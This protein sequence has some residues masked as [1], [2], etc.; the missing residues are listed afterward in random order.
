MKRFFWLIFVTFLSFSSIKAQDFDFEQAWNRIKKYEN[1]GLPKSGLALTDSIYQ[2]GKK[3]GDIE[4]QVK[5]IVYR[6]KYMT[7][8]KEEGLVET[9][10]GMEKEIETAEF[11]AKPLMQS[12]LADFYWGYY[13]RNYWKFHNR[14]ELAEIKPKDIRTWDLKT[15]VV[16][17]SKYHE[18]ALSEEELL[19]ETGVESIS[20]LIYKG[21]SKETSALRP[22]LYDLLANRALAFYSNSTTG[23]IKPK[24]EFVM[25]D[26]RYFDNAELFTKMKITS[27]DSLN[28]DYKALLIYQKLIDFH[29]NDMDKSAL[30]DVDLARIWFVFGKTTVQNKKNLILNALFQLKNKAPKNPITSEVIYT[31]AKV[32]Y[33]YFTGENSSV[34]TNRVEALKLCEQVI[35]KYPESYGASQ[36]ASLKSKIIIKTFSLKL[37]KLNSPK[38]PMLAKLTYRNSFK[39]YLRIYKV[40]T[41]YKPQK[42]TDVLK[43]KMVLDTVISVPEIKD[44]YGHS[45]KFG[46]RNLPVGHYY[47]VVSHVQDFNQSENQL[48][49]TK[50]WSTNMSMVEEKN[51]KQ[52]GNNF[53]V[54]DNLTGQATPNITFKI[55][56]HKYN[57]KTRKYEYKLQKTLKTDKNGKVEVSKQSYYSY[58]IELENGDDKVYFDDYFYSS[59]G[60][61]YNYSGKK[62]H[63]FTDRAIYR[64]GQTMYF[65]G[66]LIQYDKDGNGKEVV[67]NQKTNIY[68]YDANHQK[69]KTLELSTNEYG[70]VSG[71]FDLPTGRLGGQWHIKWGSNTKYFSVE[72]YKRPKFFVKA[73][74]VEKS[75]KINGKV[76]LSG[77]AKAYAGF[78]I[79][80]AKVEYSVTR[81]PRIPYWYYWWMP[82]PSYSNKVILNGNTTTDENGEYTIDFVAEPD[83]SINPEW[84]P[85]FTYQINVSVTD[86]NGETQTTSYSVKVGYISLLAHISVSNLIEIKKQN[87][88]YV[89]TRNLN[90]EKIPSSGK[91]TIEQ[92]ETPKTFFKKD[93][94]S[95]TDTFLLTEQ[96]FKKLFPSDIYNNENRTETWKT[97]KTVYSEKISIDGDSTFSNDFIKKF[98]AGM[99]KITYNTQ[100]KFGEEVKAIKYFTIYNQTSKK[101]IEHKMLTTQL[102]QYSYQPGEAAQIFVSSADKNILVN[103]S[104]EQN[105]KE[106]KSGTLTLNNETQSI[107]FPLEEKH[108]GNIVFHAYTTKNSRFY[109]STNTIYVPWTNK[110]LTVEFE[111]FRNK[112]QPGQKEEWKMKV[113]GPKGEKFAAEFVAT[114]Y[115]AS[116]ESFKK[117]SWYLSPFSNFYSQ[118]SYTDHYSF[119]SVNSSSYNYS[120]N[121]PKYAK[122][123][124]YDNLKLFGLN[125]NSNYY[126]YSYDELD[127]DNGTFGDGF[128]ESE[129]SGMAMDQITSTGGKLNKLQKKENKIP[130]PKKKGDLEKPLTEQQKQGKGEGGESPKVKIRTKLQENAFFMPHISTDTDGKFVLK[131]TI[132]EALT[133]WKMIGL[134]HTPDLKTGH[135]TNTLKTQKELMVIP[136]APRFFRENDKMKFSAKVSNIS[137][138]KLSGKV[139]LHLLNA[140][141]MIIADK[142]FDLKEVDKNFSLEAGKSQAFFW[143][144]TI[145]DDIEIA[146][147]RIVAVGGKFSDG[148]EA[149]IPVLPNRMLVT[150]TFPLPIRGKQ[151]KTF[152]FKNM[153]K[154]GKSNTLKNHKLTLEFT[155]NPVWYAVQ[156]LPYLMEYPYECAEQTFNRFYANSI[157]AHIVSEKPKIKEIFEQWEKVDTS[158]LLSNL[159][160]NQE[161]KSV[162]L[163]ETPWVM[164]A[165][166][167]TE[168]KK[169]IALLFNYSKMAKNL[170]SAINKLKQM[171]TPN[172]GWAWF[173]GMRD[174]RYITQYIVTGMARLQKI[175]IKASKSNKVMK[176]IDKAVPYLDDRM[177]EDYEWIMKHSLD[178]QADHLGYYAIQYLYARSYFGFAE[179]N[180]PKSHQKAYDYWMRQAKKYWLSK[181]KMSQGMLSVALSRFDEKTVASDIIASLKEHALMDEEMGMY[182]KENTGGYYWY[183]APIETQSVLIE[184]FDEVKQD[185]KSVEEMQIWLLKQKQ[186]Q[187][188]K[189]TTATAD[190]CYALLLKGTDFLSETKIVDITIGKEKIVPEK[191][192]AGTGYFSKVWNGKEITENMKTIKVTN[193]NPNIAWGGMYW[194][195]FEQLDKI[196][197]AETNLKLEKQLFIEKQTDQGKKLYAITNQNQLKLGDKI[198]VR[199]V[200]TT[201]RD[202]DYVHLKDM[203][204]AAL[205]P[206]QVFSTY[207]WQDGLGY[208]Q[209]TKDASTN[210]F[211]DHLPKGKYVF[212]YTL[213]VS[214]VGDFSNGI[215]SIQC[216]YAPEFSSHSEGIRIQVK[217]K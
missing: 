176:M 217:E 49:F 85:E 32:Y 182:W 27:P 204:A 101:P 185:S 140:Q 208:Y 163:E 148:E 20:D 36:A 136:N 40:P 38:N 81:Q 42:Y 4:N 67:S 167:E 73:D 109:S 110:Q 166:S 47:A 114:L 100:D 160:K 146:A 200:L 116:L 90:G 26:A 61:N 170:N 215:T 3:V 12:M 71:Q 68:L 10:N 132:P 80:D 60:S 28:F 104:I 93:Y 188:W 24:D 121:K 1:K 65:K 112:L 164:Q 209:S 11:P 147:Y 177:K 78:S 179:Y 113:S 197:A 18:L 157:A 64:P 53:I 138:E 96:Q 91:L 192:E 41:K 211:I 171:Q 103:Y 6:F 77:K 8:F 120:W 156:A 126:Y 89:Y 45:V 56:Q 50:F 59:S 37:E 207:R 31:I 210:F 5:A 149:P 150:E 131:F 14:S 43:E 21:D 183:Q 122:Y 130:H 189:T 95:K 17:A 13:K 2:A 135:I 83:L 63:F 161:L 30:I 165:K 35:K 194:Q 174:D 119:V 206:T 205:E 46:L 202:M 106:L 79:S 54:S 52:S 158:A 190:A 44:Y 69:V 152:V 175:G 214:Q 75:Y 72:E 203:R 142:S 198:T 168:R 88:I 111:T 102:S 212:E 57:Y 19:K 143:D 97:L 7:A 118:I 39:A 195:Y 139:T 127:D 199:I 34:K 162:L 92:L 144:I 154:M 22:S 66:I 108:R 98:K 151:S 153:S 23:L 155:S 123:R 169:R 84:K 187:D 129:E 51:Y 181:N 159:E 216:M 87:P 201:D 125:F 124:R 48:A 86:V 117:H 191:T 70:S 76:Q 128:G 94:L 180:L 16:E 62:M 193:P 196:T 99:Y 145:P 115:D 58:N 133:E 29:M 134:A 33:S 137:E 184:A 107:Q 105:G 9:I 55:Y 82:T 173:P 74:P 172:G 186:T 25:N 178:P 15:I 141:N 213:I